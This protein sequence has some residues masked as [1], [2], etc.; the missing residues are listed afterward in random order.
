[1][2]RI[3]K[4]VND[5]KTSYKYKLEMCEIILWHSKWIY[6]HRRR[7][8]S[9]VY[10]RLEIQCASQAQP[11]FYFELGAKFRSANIYWEDIFFKGVRDF[12]LHYKRFVTLTNTYMYI[13]NIFE[14]FVLFGIFYLALS[15]NCGFSINRSFQYVFTYF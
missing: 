4:L 12:W 8:W 11:S 2:V 9:Q 14:F 15:T 3:T 5:Y 1:M 7:V 10:S 6:M 13:F